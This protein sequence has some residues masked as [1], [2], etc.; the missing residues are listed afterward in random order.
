MVQGK[1]NSKAND[2]LSMQL[3]GP[4]ESDKKNRVNETRWPTISSQEGICVF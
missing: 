1:K 3:M 4:P 2:C